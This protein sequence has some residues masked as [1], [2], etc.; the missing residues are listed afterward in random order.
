MRRSGSS[1]D[2][3]PAVAL[4]LSAC[5]GWSACSLTLDD[6]LL[7]P[8]GSA[9]QGADAGATDANGDEDAPHDDGADAGELD[10]DASPPVGC[11]TSADCVTSHGCLSGAC[12][13]AK[14]V[15][16]YDVCKQPDTC[17]SAVCD[18][19]ARTCGAASKHDFHVRQFA[20]GAGIGCGGAITR[21]F[22]VIH[23]YVF[24]GTNAGVFAFRTAGGPDDDTPIPV[25]GLGFFPTTIIASERRVFFLGS[26]VTVTGSVSSR[27]A[28]A[29]LD[30]P[31]NPFEAKLAVTNV[32]GT[33]NRP[34][35]SN[36]R[37]LPFAA[38]TA[39]LYEAS[40]ASSFPMV[41][42]EAPLVEPLDLIATAVPFS[43][44]SSVVATSGTRA[45]F[46]SGANVAPAFGTFV[47]S[48]GSAAPKGGNDVPFPEAGAVSGGHVFT[49]HET[50]AVFWGYGQ[51]VEKDGVATMRA[52][53]GS[54]LVASET[55][56]FDASRS[57]D[58]ETFGASPAV[59]A[60]TTVVG[61]AA[62][63]DQNRVLVTAATSSNVAQSSV[64]FAT[65]SP[66]GPIQ[67]AEG[68]PRRYVLPAPIANLAAAADRGLGYVLVSETQ[69][70]ASVHV[71]DPGC[72]P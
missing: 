58:I 26:A 50:G 12:D 38:G 43:T 45:V 35:S 69:T 65:R 62:F 33:L 71:F 9:A 49:S 7:G 21:C 46:V 24:V 13:D 23:P 11:T 47:S 52:A 17:S 40:S 4:A 41:Q 18:T 14:H 28:L 36:F 53:R 27:V 63:V 72:A 3:L 42:L 25:T 51:K 44:G 37:L 59:A 64:Q 19:T 8:D 54:F 70:T 10:A 1:M 32:L 66:L 30:V 34:S 22:A 39:L 48:A 55:A 61:P 29:W 5:L 60:G 15:C 56:G 68:T 20:V 57:F 2:R 6:A 67:N 16:V 31:S